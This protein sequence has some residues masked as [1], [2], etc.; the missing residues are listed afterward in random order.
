MIVSTRRSLALHADARRDCADRAGAVV[1]EDEKALL[2]VLQ[3]VLTIASSPALLHADATVV[4]RLLVLGLSLQTRARAADPQAPA[5]ATMRSSL[6]SS[7]TPSSASGDASDPRGGEAGATTPG[8]IG[9]RLP[10]PSS[11]S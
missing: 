10:K 5:S 1:G 9:G 7:S 4:N 6:P 2:K 11:T 3:T 8:G